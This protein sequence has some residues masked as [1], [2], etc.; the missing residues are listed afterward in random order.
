M[1]Y[2][3]IFSFVW[4]L[5]NVMVAIICWNER[6]RYVLH[7]MH[8]PLVAF[9][10]TVRCFWCSLIVFVPMIFLNNVFLQKGMT[11]VAFNTLY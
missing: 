11:G 10:L 7:R 3:L 2:I 9:C 1:I 4:V 6:H 8:S 5:A